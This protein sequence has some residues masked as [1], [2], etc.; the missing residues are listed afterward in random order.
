MSSSAFNEQSADVGELHALLD[1]IAARGLDGPTKHELLELRDR[2]I[3][4]RQRL[5]ARQHE[6]INELSMA[7]PQ[8]LGGTLPDVLAKRLQISRGEALRRIDEARRWAARSG[9]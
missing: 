9:R 4:V 5:S 8:E 1:K 6:I 3:A 7:S 2:Y